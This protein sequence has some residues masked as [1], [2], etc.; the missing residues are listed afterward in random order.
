MHFLPDVQV[1]CEV[2]QGKR[3][4]R[5]T[6]EVTYRGKTIADIL[7]MTIE[8]AVSFF[9]AHPKIFAWPSACAMLAGSSPGSAGHHPFGRRSRSGSGRNLVGG[10]WTR[11]AGRATF[12]DSGCCV[13]APRRYRCKPDCDRTQ[14]GPAFCGGGMWSGCSMCCKPKAPPMPGTKKVQA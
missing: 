13:A 4:N 1:T 7:E 9:E 10:T 2:C 11:S 6:L 12:L 14:H 3:Y 5:E 8:D